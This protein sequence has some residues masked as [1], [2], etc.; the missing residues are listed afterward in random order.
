MMIKSFLKECPWGLTSGS[1]R[2]GKAL[3]PLSLAQGLYPVLNAQ[4][5]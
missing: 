5:Y 2:S 1:E 4:T 3:E